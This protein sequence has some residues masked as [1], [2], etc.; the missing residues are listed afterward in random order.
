MLVFVCWNQK[1]AHDEILQSCTSAALQDGGPA[2]PCTATYRS[3]AATT[4]TIT[5]THT[6]QHALMKKSRG[7]HTSNVPCDGLE[8]CI[9]CLQTV[10]ART[11]SS[12][13]QGTKIMDGWKYPSTYLYRLPLLYLNRF[14]Q[15]AYLQ[16]HNAVR[17]GNLHY[18]LRIISLYFIVHKVAITCILQPRSELEENWRGKKNCARSWVRVFLT[19]PPPTHTFCLCARV[20]QISGAAFQEFSETK[21]I[22]N[23]PCVSIPHYCSAE[24]YDGNVVGL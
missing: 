3:S 24:L 10:C 6:P 23:S 21:W 5:H 12:R 9:H 15:P 18:I 2:G 4:H 7:N 20:Q 17:R 11:S 1:L 8:T 19:S 16:A 14:N 22:K 13:L